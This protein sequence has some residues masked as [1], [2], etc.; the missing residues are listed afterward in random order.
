MISRNKGVHHFRDKSNLII[1]T[2]PLRVPIVHQFVVERHVSHVFFLTADCI[3]ITTA[4]FLTKRKFQVF[5]HLK[6]KASRAIN[7]FFFK[8]AINVFTIDGSLL[9]TSIFH[10]S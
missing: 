9:R 6:G 5:Y 2:L 10:Y 7:L 3:Q 4:L 1:N 8:V